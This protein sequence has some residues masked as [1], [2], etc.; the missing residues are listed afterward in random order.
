MKNWLHRLLNPHCPQCALE[1]K[2]AHDRQLEDKVCEKCEILQIQLEIANIEKQKLLDKVI[3]SNEKEPVI[4][5]PIVQPRG[6]FI[7]WAVKRQVLEAEDRVAAKL[8]KDKEKEIQETV[9]ASSDDPD[10]KALEEEM[11]IIEKDRENASKIG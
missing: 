6:R 4:E 1:D 7:P 8:K 9:V 2:L 3:G 10:V 11:A 5:Q